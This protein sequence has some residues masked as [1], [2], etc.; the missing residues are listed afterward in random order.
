MTRE[1]IV[2]ATVQEELAK[3]EPNIWAIFDLLKRDSLDQNKLQAIAD[4]W[5]E[6]M[7]EKFD[8]GTNRIKNVI[9]IMSNEDEEE[10]LNG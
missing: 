1:E 10:E 3:D 7:K 4:S 9:E 2:M 5:S 8:A 6:G